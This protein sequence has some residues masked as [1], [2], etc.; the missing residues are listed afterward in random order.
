MGVA[1]RRGIKPVPTVSF[2]PSS[3]G[4]MGRGLKISFHFVYVHMCTIGSE[5]KIVGLLS[6][7][8]VGQLRLNRWSIC[9]GQ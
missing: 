4:K 6:Y 3:V 2:P 9:D 8:G 5:L 1:V 7:L